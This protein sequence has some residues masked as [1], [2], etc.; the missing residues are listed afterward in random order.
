MS[1]YHYLI[2]EDCKQKINLGKQSL[3][4][5]FVVNM[6]SLEKGKRE[7]YLNKEFKPRVEAIIKEDCELGRIWRSSDYSVTFLNA[8]LF[9][10]KH[11]GHKIRL[12]FDAGY[13]I[14]KNLNNWNKG[15]T[16]IK[17]ADNQDYRLPFISEDDP[18]YMDKKFKRY[19]PKK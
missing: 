3:V 12:Q 19:K 7:E 10:L 18:L 8:F 9:A 6:L 2:C 14:I 15:K 16:I 11:S 13:P 17:Q 5:D 4:T 1:D